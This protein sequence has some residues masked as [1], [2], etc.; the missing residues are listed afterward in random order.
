MG[1][2][3]GYRVDDVLRAAVAVFRAEG[4]HRTSV[5]ALVTGTGLNRFALYEKFG[6]KEG[7]FY[8]TLDFYHHVMIEDELLAPLYQPGASLDSVLEMLATM[9]D[10]NAD[11]SL[12]SGCLIVNAN[13]ELGGQNARVALT[14]EAVM[15]TFRHAIDHA[16]TCAQQR[17]GLRK[18]GSIPEAA[19]YIVVMIRAFFSLAYISREAADRLAAALIKEVGSWRKAPRDA[20]ARGPAAFQNAGAGLRR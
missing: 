11:V 2:Q 14:A 12:R 15:A 20:P 3:P 8:A 18:Q 7:L 5:E 17:G 13:T 16:L 4:F 10:I 19:D 1:R 9:R 6:G